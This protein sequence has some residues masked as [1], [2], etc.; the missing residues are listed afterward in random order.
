MLAFHGRFAKYVA[1]SLVFVAL[2]SAAFPMA[3]RIQAQAP[4]ARPR[5]AVLV[6]FD[7]MRGDYLQRWGDLFGDGGFR[8]LQKEGALFEN[9]HYP[10]ADTVTAAGHASILTGCSPAKHGIVDNEWYDRASGKTIYCVASERHKQVPP[11]KNQKGISPELLLAPSFADCLKDATHGRARVVS[12]SMKDR[13]AV[14]PGG[15]RANAC[16]WL[17]NTTGEFVT[18]TY[19]CDRLHPWV[20]DF[21]EAREV[22][23]WFGKAWTRLRP[24]LDYVRYSG[25]DD[26]VGEGTGV[27]QGRT[28]PHA[29]TGGLASPGASYYNALY[30]S[31]F[32]N[33]LLLDLAKRAIDAEGL[34]THDVS[35]LLCVSFSSNDAIGH[36][37]GPDSQEVLDVTLR[38]DV[39]IKDLLACLDA[40]VGKGNYVLAVTSDHGIPPLPE[41]AV[42]Q[43]K[44]ARRVQPGLLPSQAEAFLQE[45]FGEGKKGR[46]IE[47]GAMPWIYLNQSLLRDRGLGS[48]QVQD[49]LADWAKRQPD[50][51]AAYTRTQLQGDLSND[52]GLGQSVQRSFHPER[53]GDVALVPKPYHFFWPLLFGT[54]HGS[55]HSYDTHVPLLIYGPGFA[56][57]VRKEA[58][59][60]QAVAAIF[61]KLLD[62]PPPSLS[63]APV[64]PSLFQK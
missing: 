3:W 35:D 38:S 22:A 64:P 27:S 37:W 16:Y 15:R 55:P 13:S 5:L 61:A 20:A 44:D 30:N 43:G 6:I 31:P 21:N 60:P 34:G 58:V 33:E 1:G 32:G 28:F 10:Y 48:G 14:L 19:Y 45:K 59:T 29:L 53:S 47:A 41:V 2:W 39:I 62:V 8:R 23:R 56:P 4:A 11:G 9:C 26:V 36:C 42:A 7:Q 63:D 24:D 46:W 51:L 50:I 52:D 25:P 12:L 17:D 54:M 40:K 57:G 18:S 49:A